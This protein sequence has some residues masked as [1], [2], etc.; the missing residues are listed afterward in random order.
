MK[1][2]RIRIAVVGL[3]FGRHIVNELL[4]PRGSLSMELAG[5]CDA[6][7]VRLARCAAESGVR[8]YHSLEEIL[9]DESI[10]AVGLY[11]PPHHRAELIGRILRSGRSVMTTKPFE[12][13][14]DAAA[15]VLALAKKRNLVVHLNSP[16][17]LPAPDQRRIMEWRR[18]F[19]LGE[20]VSAFW[21]TYACYHETAD[22]SWMDDPVR[23]PA[24]PLFRLGIYGI[25][26]LV[27]LCG[28]P[29]ACHVVQSRRSTGRPTADN[30]MLT[31]SFRN[32]AIGCVAASF[33]IN[34]GK[35]YSNRLL[36]HYERGTIWRAMP[37][38]PDGICKLVLQ[39]T[40]SR[41]ERILREDEINTDEHS[42]AYQWEEFRQAI[43]QGRSISAEYTSRIV[44]S[45]RVV[46]SFARQCQAP[47]GMGRL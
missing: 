19:D 37:H 8:S 10:E 15:E 23:C 16:S 14:P 43:R 2:K 38:D 1:D 47:E 34:D 42:G 36:I 26:D 18:E 17:P 29:S 41:G 12:D 6:D 13:D 28:E 30:A 11:T 24:A 9:A 33:R 25:N 5:I 40:G 7:S 31:I 32:G 22:G 20:P 21:E 27:E 35:P 4:G 46:N 44:S 3:G 39:G 45:I